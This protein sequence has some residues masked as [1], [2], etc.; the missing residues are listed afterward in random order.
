MDCIVAVDE[1]WGIGRENDMLC[2]ISTD[3]KRFRAITSGH[4]LVLGRKTLESF[5]NQKPLP[6]RIH[7]VLTQ[8][9]DYQAEGVTLCH[10]IADLPT[11][12]KQYE[13]EKVFV[14][15]GGSVYRQMLPFCQKAYVTKIYDTFPADTYFPNLDEEE[16][17]VL[18]EKGQMQEE[19]GVRFSFD[20]YE[21]V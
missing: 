8:N 1:K 5:P 3:L 17:W 10:S 19:K 2:P 6:N 13:G 20:L 15:G 21:R 18:V 12:L 14:V 16:G 4:I 9:R 11:V 7:I